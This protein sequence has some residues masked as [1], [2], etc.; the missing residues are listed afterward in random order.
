MRGREGDNLFG[1]EVW[2]P[3]SLE[4]TRSTLTWL[5]NNRSTKKEH[6]EARFHLCFLGLTYWVSLCS[7]T[8]IEI[9]VF[10]RN[11]YNA[12][13]TKR[14][15]QKCTIKQVL[16]VYSQSYVATS[17]MYFHNVFISP[18]R[19]LISISSHPRQSLTTTNQ[20]SVTMAM[21]IL[22]LLYT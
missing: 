11:R 8:N 9:T 14:T 2:S 10:L 15:L 19:N 3:R 1:V 16:K 22:G 21:T 4:H 18:Q 17:I 7:F 12:H 6:H 20:L 13:T 5:T